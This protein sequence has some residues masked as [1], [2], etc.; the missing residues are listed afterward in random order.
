MSVIGTRKNA[1]RT[2]ADRLRSMGR[3]SY[4]IVDE[5]VNVE[6]MVGVFTKALGVMSEGMGD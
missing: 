2:S 4:R 6:V 3:E 1:T 5:E